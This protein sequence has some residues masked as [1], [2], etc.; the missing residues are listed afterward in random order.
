MTSYSS[1]R[2]RSV[3]LPGGTLRD[4]FLR[5]WSRARGLQR[6]L[7][8]CGDDLLVENSLGEISIFWDEGG[9]TFPSASSRKQRLGARSLVVAHLVEFG[10][11]S[12]SRHPEEV[13]NLVERA[14]KFIDQIVEV[15]VYR[16]GVFDFDG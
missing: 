14:G 7:C 11:Q 16:K 13:K 8:R 1:L 5:H 6:T 2:C 4:A 10:N 15:G 9:E 3:F 12:L